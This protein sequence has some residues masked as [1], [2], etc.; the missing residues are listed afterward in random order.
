ME[1]ELKHL[2][3][4]LPYRLAMGNKMNDSEILTC[5]NVDHA[6]KYWKPILRPM[7]DLIETV[8]GKTLIHE[9]ACVAYR[10]IFHHDPEWFG[11][12]EVFE[13]DNQWGLLGWDAFGSMS[14]PDRIGFS[15][16]FNNQK[17]FKFT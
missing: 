15:V 12:T 16:D 13:A 5:S 9:L 7:S 6:L 3:S 1:L 11:N 4:Y 14:N 2:S 17:D 8:N 10:Q